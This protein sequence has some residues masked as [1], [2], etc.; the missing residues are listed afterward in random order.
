MQNSHISASNILGVGLGA[1]L[2]CKDW[3]A[4]VQ[5]G[6]KAALYIGGADVG[7]SAVRVLVER[8]RNGGQLPPKTIAKTTMV[9][10]SNWKS[11]MAECT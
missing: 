7:A 4:G 3:K 10:S 5:S 1:Y 8:I 9:D 11:T 2:T 6:N